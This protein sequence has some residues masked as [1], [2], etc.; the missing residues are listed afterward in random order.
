MPAPSDFQSVEFHGW[1]LRLRPASE[2]SA[3]SAVKTTVIALGVEAT[4]GAGEAIAGTL[5]G[6]G[7]VSFAPHDAQNRFVCAF[8]CPQSL[9]TTG[10]AD[11]AACAAI[12]GCTAAG[13]G[14]NCAT[15]PFARSPPPASAPTS[16][17]GELSSNAVRAVISAIVTRASAAPS[18]AYAASSTIERHVAASG[19]GSF[20]SYRAPAFL[21]ASS[22][23]LTS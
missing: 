2:P 4:D 6:F 1:T 9:Q 20:T 21:N 3:R 23:K 13:V 10:P 18:G 11:G 19:S 12:G 14:G 8:V 5:P 16:A 17:S 15:A 22:G 7:S